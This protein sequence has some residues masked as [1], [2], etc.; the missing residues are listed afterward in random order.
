MRGRSLADGTLGECGWG[1]AR[2]KDAVRA[3]SVMR[4]SAS[5]CRSANSV[6][7]RAEV[8]ALPPEGPGE[9]VG[10]W[11]ARGGGGFGSPRG[12]TVAVALKP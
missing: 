5:A 10:G 12:T 6:A 7:T 1:G 9:G 2:L 4:G 11:G 8:E 3:M